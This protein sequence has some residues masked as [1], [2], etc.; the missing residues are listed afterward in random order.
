MPG[1]LEKGMVATGDQ[2]SGPSTRSRL[3]RHSLS[4]SIHG[5]SAEGVIHPFPELDSRGNPSMT[6]LPPN[7]CQAVILIAALSLLAGATLEEGVV[8]WRQ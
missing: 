5:I 3:E 6:N 7:P 2:A 1:Y 8:V 4:F